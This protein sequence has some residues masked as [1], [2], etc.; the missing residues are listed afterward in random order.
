MKINIH[1]NQ[2][3]LSFAK[4]FN[5]V[6]CID[7]QKC[8]IINFACPNSNFCSFCIFNTDQKGLCRFGL[9][10]LFKNNKFCQS[11]SV[12]WIVF[13]FHKCT[14]MKFFGI[15]Q[16]MRHFLCDLSYSTLANGFVPLTLMKN[17]CDML[18]HSWTKKGKFLFK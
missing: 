10:Y 14:S 18:H 12:I 3:C 2:S 13:S 6:D 1:F 8:P 16:I 7:I 17:Y 9:L 11:K 4:H 5:L 15:L